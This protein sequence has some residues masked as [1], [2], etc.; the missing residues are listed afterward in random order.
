VGQLLRGEGNGGESV[1][2][3]DGTKEYSTKNELT[4]TKLGVGE[5]VRAGCAVPLATGRGEVAGKT[6]KS[7]LVKELSR[8]GSKGQHRRSN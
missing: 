6:S 3:T 2:N 4:P 8:Q 7:T 1:T 5:K